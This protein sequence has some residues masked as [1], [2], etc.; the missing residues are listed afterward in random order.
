M[1]LR[2]VE[3]DQHIIVSAT[4]SFT[5]RRLLV[6]DFAKAEALLAEALKK[7]NQGKL[8]LASPAILV[9]PLEMVEEGLSPVEERIFKELAVGAGARSVVVWVGSEL[10]DQQVMDK[11]DQV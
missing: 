4:E 6:G 2:D 11:L 1:S 9:Q 3:S 10:S 5:T 7:I 8:K